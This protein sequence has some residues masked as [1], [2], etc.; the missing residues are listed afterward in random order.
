M[1]KKRILLLASFLLFIYALAFGQKHWMDLQSVEDVCEYNPSAMK[2]MLEQFDLNRPGLENVRSAYADNNVVDA[3]KYLLS[4]YRQSS[5]A[6]DLRK[7]LPETT[8]KTVAETD[9]ILNNVFTIQNVRGEVKY[10]SDGHRDWYYKGPNNDRE[11][12]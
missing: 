8:T 10:G 6:P 9:T 3:C 11:W 4:Y 2:K 7:S 5:N 1:L 12:A